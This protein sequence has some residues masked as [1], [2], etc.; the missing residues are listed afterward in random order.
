MTR[1]ISTPSS[2]QEKAR[3][4]LGEPAMAFIVMLLCWL[5]A[6]CETVVS[7]SASTASSLTCESSFLTGSAQ[8]PQQKLSKK[9][10]AASF[11]T[12][13]IK[14][15]REMALRYASPEAVAKLDWSTPH[16]GDFP[17]YDDKMILYY[18]GGLARVHFQQQENGGYKIADIHNY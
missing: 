6:G 11:L 8:V 2:Q 16:G 12:A 15:D 3:P 14:Q 7:P 18:P 1:P 17:Y 5:V 9:E 10:V 4:R 13:F